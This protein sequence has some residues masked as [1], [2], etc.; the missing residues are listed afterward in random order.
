[1]HLSSSTST[2]PSSA[3]LCEAPVGQTVTQ[4]AASQCRQ[5]FGKWTMRASPA[6]PTTWPP[7]GT[8]SKVW[9]RLSQ[10]PDTSGP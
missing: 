5:D 1:M 4:G 10:A 6:S 8:T 7:S 9:M 3:R 2:M